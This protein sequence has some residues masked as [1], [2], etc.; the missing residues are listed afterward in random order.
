MKRDKEKFNDVPELRLLKI[1]KEA[2]KSYGLYQWYQSRVTK[3]FRY[4]GVGIGDVHAHVPITDSEISQDFIRYQVA[5]R[6]KT[7]RAWRERL[8]DLGNIVCIPDVDGGFSTLVIGMDFV[9]DAG[10]D[11]LPEPFRKFVDQALPGTKA[12]IQETLLSDIEAIITSANHANVPSS[13]LLKSL[14]EVPNRPW[15][16]LKGRRGLTPKILSNMLRD[17]GIAPKN[18]KFDGVVKKGYRV[19]ELLDAAR[20]IR[21][22][23]P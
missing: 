14:N 23:Q 6:P 22:R 2:P 17:F 21:N 18:I 12:G 7:I 8:K 13:D 10:M 9:D 1:Q 20:M 16:K 15:R 19:S 5:V 4:R 11:D 3:V